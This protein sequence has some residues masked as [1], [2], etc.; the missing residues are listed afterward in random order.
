MRDAHR[1]VGE[2]QVRKRYLVKGPASNTRAAERRFTLPGQAPIFGY[3]PGIVV[4]GG[5]RLG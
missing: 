1:L 4:I 3:Q 2:G 5:V